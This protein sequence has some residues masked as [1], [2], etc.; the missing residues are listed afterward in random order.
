MGT[1]GAVSALIP[2]GSLLPSSP[3]RT[4]RRL[5]TLGVCLGLALITFAVF[6]QTTRFHFLNFDDDQFISEN[7]K[8]AAGFSAKGIAWAFTAN[9]TYNEPGAE[10]WEPLTL[11]SRLADVQLHGLNP[12]CHHLSNVLF[13]LAAGLVLFGALKALLRSTPRSGV[14]AALFLIHPLH[15][16]AVAWL[17]ARKDILNGLFFF[18]TIWAYAWYAAR[19]AW[20]RYLL[21]CVSFLC[22]NM[23]KPMAVSLPFVLLLLDFWPLGRLKWPLG[24]RHSLRLGVEKIPLVVIASLVSLLAIIDQQRHGAMGD[25]TLCPLSV[26]LGNAVISYAVYLGQT[27]VPSGLSIFYPHPGNSLNWPLAA[28]SVACCFLITGLCLVQ[29]K[30]RPWLLVGW[31]WFVVVLLPVSGLIQI[32]EMA[33]ADRYT[34]VALVGV[35]ILCVQEAA[36]SANACLFHFPSKWRTVIIASTAA[37]VIAVSAWLAWQQTGTWRNSI[38]VFSQALA[39]TEDNYIA[40]ANL[41]AALYA[42]G[43]K[44]EGL[45]HYKEAI[46]LHAPALDYHQRAGANAEERG[47]FQ[48]AIYHYGK[49]V[50]FLPWS[51]PVH[52]RL[53][54]VLSKTGEYGRAL[55]QYNEA[56]RYDRNAIPPRLGIARVLIAQQRF[57]E[58]RVIIEV[59][60][61]L[62]P[63]NEEARALLRSLPPA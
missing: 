61:R 31:G 52:Q 32:G 60:R 19:P 58:A 2:T 38:S 30:A 12:G 40:H 16:E 14:I 17:S 11:L 9:L 49:I 36:T 41:G 22:A 25:N 10:Y 8:L 33:R 5:A 37:A 45:Q 56:L 1:A 42:A 18:A 53:G 43:H 44:D 3:T 6:G 39:V 46:R 57:L 59:I 7:P 20:R 23:A 48:N 54:G 35:F 26:R 15:V 21:V 51:A 29:A 47:D 50:T 4:P 63:A 28:A 34:Y 13:H 55:V 62:E 27:F 24:D